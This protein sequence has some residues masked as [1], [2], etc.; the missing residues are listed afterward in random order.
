M[1]MSSLRDG[2]SISPEVRSF[3]RAIKENPDDDTPRLIFADWLQERGDAASAARGEYLRLAVRRH[4]LPPDDPDYELLKR[5]EAEIFTEHRWTW[6][7]P[8]TDAARGWAFER[9]MMQITASAEKLL[10]PEVA[11]WARTE[12]ALWIDA[13]KITDLQ[14]A[15]ITPLVRCPLLSHL[16]TLDLS[17]NRTLGT[18]FRRLLRAFRNKS[19]PYLTQLLLADNRLTGQ[20]F[21]F[22]CS[23]FPRLRTLD[24]QN[25]RLEDTVARLLAGS[26][27]ITTGITLLLGQNS[28]SSEGISLLSQTCGEYVQF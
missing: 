4:R 12:A 5:R 23:C 15:H 19:Y 17:G 14:R 13:L 2:A 3:F 9:G 18:G 7:G 25:N 22:K 26:F 28:F 6:L 27:D 10:T 21:L 16:N 20:Q 1:S 11:D 24:L 8:L